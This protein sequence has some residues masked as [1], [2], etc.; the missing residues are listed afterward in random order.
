M[1]RTLA[2]GAALWIAATTPVLAATASEAF[3]DVPSNCWAANA[4]VEMAVK[5]SLMNVYPDGT[6]RGNEPF[7]RAQLADSLDAFVNELEAESNTKWTDGA[8][9]NW[10]LGDVPASDPDHDKILRMVNVY[11]LWRG[12]PTVDPDHFHPDQTVTREEVAEVVSNLLSSG[13]AR[14]A[15][16]PR[17]PR[18]PNNPFKDLTPAQWAYKAILADDSRYRVMIGFPDVTFRPDSKLTRYQYAAIG[19]QTFGMI[20]NLVLNNPNQYLQPLAATDRFQGTRPIYVGYDGAFTTPAPSTSEPNGGQLRGVFYPGD[21]F[22]M[23]D[24][25]AGGGAA[26]PNAF[27]GSLGAY[28][29][30]GNWNTAS[31]QFQP[32]IGGRYNV[33]DTNASLV[34]GILIYHN[35]GP[36]G[37]DFRADVAVGRSFSG[38]TASNNLGG[39]AAGQVDLGVGLEVPIT[40]NVAFHLDPTLS[41]AQPAGDSPFLLDAG[42]S[43]G[44]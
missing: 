42:L 11:H 27:G 43:F 40:K 37:I 9:Y 26:A 5:R 10:T 21:G 4:V 29:A 28:G 22:L 24:A 14:K 3:R 6:F 30:W 16:M 17:D 20:R 36:V 31:W 25:R 38:G 35:F 13:E 18:S 2:L 15:V 23:V 7:T 1:R 34:P 12:V 8:P 44:S 41:F 19:A 39:N 32:Y 33:L